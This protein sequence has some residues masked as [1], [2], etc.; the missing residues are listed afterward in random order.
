MVESLIIVGTMY[1]KGVALKNAA[2]GSGQ[3]DIVLD[4]VV[5]R[6]SEGS[7]LDCSHGAFLEHNCRH[8]E[9]AAVVCGGVSYISV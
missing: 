2:F 3:G 5:C 7:L 6:G 9:D 1:G 4:D 8:S